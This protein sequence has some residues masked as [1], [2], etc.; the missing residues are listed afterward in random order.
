MPKHSIL[1]RDEMES[2]A[3]WLR[4]AGGALQDAAARPHTVNGV[5]LDQI[6][7]AAEKGLT[8]LRH[9]RECFR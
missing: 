4:V 7:E 5:E 3:S 8:K 2:A 1:G 6:I 9:M